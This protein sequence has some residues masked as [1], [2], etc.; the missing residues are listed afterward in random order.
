MIAHFPGLPPK[1]C[2]HLKGLCKDVSASTASLVSSMDFQCEDRA[3]YGGLSRVPAWNRGFKATDV[4]MDSST[5][6][7]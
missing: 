2:Q 7:D 5:Q 3:V 6:I 1:L 4:K